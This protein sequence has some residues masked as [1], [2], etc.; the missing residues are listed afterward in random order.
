LEVIM[1]KTLSIV[2]AAGAFMA[3]AS[4]AQAVSPAPVNSG[5]D[6]ILVA[7]GCGPGF[8]RGPLGHCRPNGRPVVVCRIVRTPMGPRRV[9]R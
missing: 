3:L 9:C 8:H 1:L 2:A 5:S 4:S 6:V 7:Q